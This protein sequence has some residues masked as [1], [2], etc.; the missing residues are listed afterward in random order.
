M[1][2]VRRLLTLGFIALAACKAPP[3]RR[4]NEV[5]TSHGA[6]ILSYTV[7]PSPIRP[8]ELFSITTRVFDAKS[9]QAVEDA[10]VTVD[11]RMPQHGHGMSTKPEADRGECDAGGTCRHPGGTYVTRGMKFHM[12]GEWTLTFAVDGPHGMDRAELVYT[13]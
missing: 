10:T 2:R 11:A 1:S 13:L 7:E 4:A 6:Y 5:T 12:P 8:S 9:G 3:T